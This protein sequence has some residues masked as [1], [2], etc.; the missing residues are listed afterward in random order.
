MAGADSGI[1]QLGPD[2]G[3]DQRGVVIAQNQA[4][5][6]FGDLIFTFSLVSTSLFADSDSPCELS[7]SAKNRAGDPVS[8]DDLKQLVI[9]LSFA[10][11]S[12]SA[13]HNWRT[14][15]WSDSRDSVSLTIG[16]AS[17][18]DADRVP[19]SFYFLHARVKNPSDQIIYE[20]SVQLVRVQ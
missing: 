3:P 11:Y 19:A 9:S 14:A 5:F 13:D 8:S 12:R 4:T 10:R 18:S 20:A 7:V 15:N 1:D 2:V 17:A 6:D 16:G